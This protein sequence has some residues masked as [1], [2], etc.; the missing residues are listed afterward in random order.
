M[1]DK[2]EGDTTATTSLGMTME[3]KMDFVFMAFSHDLVFINQI[4]S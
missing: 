4:C 1:A 3:I 2:S